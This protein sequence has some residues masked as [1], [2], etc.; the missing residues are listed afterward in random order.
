[1]LKA[2]HTKELQQLKDYVAFLEKR[3]AS[4]HWKSVAT[5]E[6]VERTKAQYDKA[7]FR[8]KT[9]SVKR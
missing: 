4:E 8:L 5:S 1:M 9:L 7:K 6:E 2:S 3:L